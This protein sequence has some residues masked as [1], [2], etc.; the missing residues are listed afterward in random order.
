MGRY[1][2]NLTEDDFWGLTLKE[3]NALAGRHESNQEW[4]NYRAALVCAVLA[5]TAR[6]P[7][8]KR[9]PFVPDDFLPKKEHVGQTPEQIFAQVQLLNALFGGTVVEE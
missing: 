1:D 2:L 4:L 8:R 3:F 6:D 7:K 9:H 5:N